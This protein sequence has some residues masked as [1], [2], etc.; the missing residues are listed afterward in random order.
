MPLSLAD[1]QTPLTKEQV[2]ETLVDYL[3]TL[4]FP[5]TAWQPEGAALSFL[6]MMSALGASLSERVAELSKATDLEEAEGEFLDVKARSD[7]D[8]SRQA[9]VAAVFDASFINAGGTTHGPVAA[10]QIVVRSA[11][12]QLFE[13]TGSATITAS[14]TV[15]VELR[16]QIPGADGNIPAGDLQLV[17]SFAG[18]TVVFDGTLTTAGADSEQDARLRTRCRTKWGTLRV[19][20]VAE[21]VKNLALA[22]SNSIAHVSLIDNNP[23]GAGTVDVMIAA[24][25]AASGTGDVLLAQAALDDAFL[26]NG[27]SD[28]LVKAIAASV[29]T[30]PITATV[31]VSGITEAQ[32]LT[33]LNAA[34]T[35]FL[36]GSPIGGFDLSPGPTQIITRG[37]ILDAMTSVPGVVSVDMSFPAVDTTVSTV[38]KVLAT[39]N[40]LTVVV[41][42]GS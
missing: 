4:G 34:I 22:A 36:N 11:S 3:E 42:S 41:V 10:G 35:T 12:G 2:R 38:E 28:Q 30:L 18:V 6:E 8:E 31:L 33:D 9:A 14:S 29:S 37:Q 17:T 13:S 27:T 19:E 21:G 40:T 25:G 23:R 20:K 26:G 24:D 16:A 5:V 7:F 15:T 39:T 1:L 32:A